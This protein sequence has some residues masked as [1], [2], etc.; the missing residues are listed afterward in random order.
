MSMPARLVSAEADSALDA[1]AARELTRQIKVAL[2]HSYTMIIAAYRGQAW[3]SMGY[4]SWDAYCQG[5]FGNLALQPPREDRQNVIMSMREAGMSV[6]AIKGATGLGQGTVQRAVQ[7]DSSIHDAGV[8]NGTPEVEAGRDA[9]RVT[10][11]DGKSYQPTRTRLGVEPRPHRPAAPAFE[12]VPLS[13]DL[14]DLP[15]EDIG[16]EPLD[17]GSRRGSSESRVAAARRLSGSMDAALPK[18][19]RVAGELV[20]GPVGVAGD[21]DDAETFSDLAADAS[22]GIL[23]LSHV[24]AGIDASVFRGCADDAAEVSGAVT[25]ALAVLGRV[26]DDLHER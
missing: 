14:L 7:G 25:D 3:W 21:A 12:D 20:D 6:R 1:G 23:T 2:E 16:I 10:G 4:S 13:D 26:L 5:E 18:M 17:V 24:L 15:A 11:L 19:I 22:R 9:G 8:P